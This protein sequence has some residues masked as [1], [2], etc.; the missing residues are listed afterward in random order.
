MM[1]G[2]SRINLLAQMIYERLPHGTYKAT[3]KRKA[4]ITHTIED[5]TSVSINTA[6]EEIVQKV[7]G[8]LAND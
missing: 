8:R 7:K 6:L 5:S 4:C 3:G 1:T 2:D